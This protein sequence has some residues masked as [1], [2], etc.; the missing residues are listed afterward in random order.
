MNTEKKKPEAMSDM[1]TPPTFLLLHYMSVAQIGGHG[2]GAL[3]NIQAAEVSKEVISLVAWSV[4]LI[5]LPKRWTKTHNLV[6]TK[7]A[8]IADYRQNRASQ[9][10][11]NVAIVVAF[12]TDE[13]SKSRCADIPKILSATE[14]LYE[15][16][17]E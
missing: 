11:A 4:C 12:S 14:K 7:L 17:R 6:R 16:E 1:T 2:F 13:T 3:H 10:R 8:A 5:R 15:T 9:R